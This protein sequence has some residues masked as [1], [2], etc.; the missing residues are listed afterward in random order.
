MKLRAEAGA[1]RCFISVDIRN[2]YGDPIMNFPSYATMGEIPLS[3]G[4]HIANLDIP[5]LPLT[6]G[7]YRLSLWAEV[8][9]PMHK[10]KCGDYVQ[11]VVKLKVEDGDFFDKGK[12]IAPHL[13]GRV[14]VCDHSW[15]IE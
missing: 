14:V 2:I 10:L 5:R 8:K 11:N 12:R 9:S 1:D 15:T 13:S 4:I 6:P 7:T 3:Q